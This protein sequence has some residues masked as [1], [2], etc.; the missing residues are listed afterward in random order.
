MHFICV[1]CYP[2]HDPFGD[3]K[4]EPVYKWEYANCSFC[5]EEA[6]YRWW[7]IDGLPFSA[8]GNPN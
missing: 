4:V 8:E 2:K 6:N 5:P 1:E 3:G 7:P